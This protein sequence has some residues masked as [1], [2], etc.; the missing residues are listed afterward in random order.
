MGN[1]NNTSK[2]DKTLNNNQIKTN[3]NQYYSELHKRNLFISEKREAAIEYFNSFN[4][5]FTIDRSH[6]SHNLST[7][8]IRSLGRRL[9]LD[10]L[11]YKNSKQLNISVSEAIQED[12]INITHEV[13]IDSG[14][15]T[16]S[17]IIE[18]KNKTKTIKIDLREEDQIRILV[19]PSN[20]KNEIQSINTTQMQNMNPQKYKSKIIK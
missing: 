8:A 14:N 17:D 13:V 9:T 7:R 6:I 18:Y 10:T 11:F 1:K 12:S 15:N 2:T 20:K 19:I 4:T 5:N 16:T 3:Q